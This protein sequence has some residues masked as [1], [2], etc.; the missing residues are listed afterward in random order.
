[1]THVFTRPFRVRIY[2]LD[3]LGHVNN[4]VYLRYCEQAA[5][6]A[7]ESLGYTLERHRELGWVWVIR[8]TILEHVAP[9][10][11]GD[12]INVTTWLSRL[13]RASAYREYLLTREGDG[14]VIGRAQSRWV[15][16]D[17]RTGHPIRMP[18]DMWEIFQPNGKVAV[19]DLKPMRGEKP[20]ENPHRYTHRR[21]VQH[22]ELDSA[23]HVNNAIYLN[24]LEQ[25]KIE[26]CAEAGYPLSRLREIG[27]VIVQTRIEVEY[28]RPALDGDEIEV[29]SWLAAMARTHGTWAHEVY[30]LDSGE[31][32]CR[33]W[34]TG[35]FLNLE[36]HPTRAPEPFIQAVLEGP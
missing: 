20:T 27:I 34:S 19:R 17:T 7:A 12:T 5:M 21:K 24:W 9:A 32:L 8:R 25:A 36:G 26:A 30:R 2:E 23:G 3:S 22:Y 28:L 16:L 14:A 11:Y 13:T 6:E 35:A 33:A 4:A 31:L 18:P 10:R 15:L 29:R 1:M